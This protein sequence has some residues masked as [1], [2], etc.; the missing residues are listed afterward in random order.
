MKKLSILFAFLLVAAVTF[1]GCKKDEEEKAAPT[2]AFT[3]GDAGGGSRE[4]DFSSTSSYGITFAVDIAA[5]GE[6]ATFTIKKKIYASSTTESTLP[7]SGFEGQTSFSYT[8]SQTYVEADFDVDGGV[9]KIEYMFEVT[10]KQDPAKSVSKMFTVTKKVGTTPGAIIS[11]TATLGAQNASAGSSFS[12]SNGT[13]YLLADAKTN[14]SLIDFVYFY[15]ATNFATI[16]APNDVDAASVFTGTNGLSNWTTKNAT[17]FGTTT[18]TTTQ[19]D[20]IADD[21]QIV[22]ITGLA[23]TK[24]NSL[25]VGS[26]FAFQTAGGKKG[27]VKVTAL[28]AAN[29]DNISISVKMED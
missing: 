11:W 26:V 7:A 4:L 13:V 20:A 23:A 6:I 14:S 22:T 1:V 16:A 12:T 28:T 5:E 2:I 19:F 15:G 24:V 17:K 3:G 18:V 21:A 27:L 10:D 9:D 8:F 29:T 25:V